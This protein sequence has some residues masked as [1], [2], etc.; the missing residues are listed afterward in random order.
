MV[1]VPLEFILMLGYALSLGLIAL[2]SRMDSPSCAPAI[3]GSKHGRFHLS[4]RPRRLAMSERPASV[5]SFF[6]LRQGD[7]NLPCSRFRLQHLHRASRLA[8]IPAMGAK[9]E[10]SSLR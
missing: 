7:G 8:R 4:P 2:A 10:R 9:F 1:G 5:S 3:C 6:G